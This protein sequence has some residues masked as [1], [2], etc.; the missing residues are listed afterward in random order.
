M[1]QKLIEG[2]DYYINKNG[3]LV[4]SA[5]YLLKRGDCCGNGCSNCPYEYKNVEEPTRSKLLSLRKD[6]KDSF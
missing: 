4:F 2:E 5:S 3:N 1:N 6:E